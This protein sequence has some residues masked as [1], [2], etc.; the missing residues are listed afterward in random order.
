MPDGGGHT[1]S[2]CI[3]NG[4]NATVV[5]RKLYFSG[6]L[7]IGH[8]A[9][10][11]PV[12]L[13][14]KPVFA[15]YRFQLKYHFNVLLQFC[16][17]VV[18][19][20]KFFL[21]VF[22]AHDGTGCIA[23]HIGQLQVDGSIAF[24]VFELQVTVAGGFTH[25]IH[26]RSLAPGHALKLINIFFFH[27]QAHSF[28]RFVAHNFARRQGGITHRQFVNMDGSASCFHQLREAIEVASGTMV[29]DGNDRVFIMFHH[30]TDGIHGPFLHFGVRTLYGI[31]LNGIGEFTCGNRR[32]RSAT[33]PNTVIVT[34]QHNHFIAGCRCI[35]Q[36]IG[37]FAKTNPSCQHDNF[38]VGKSFLIFGMLEGKQGTTDQGLAE[39][40]AKIAGTIGGLD[41]DLI[42]C[43]VQPGSFGDIFLPQ[44]ITFLAGIG[45][46][47]YCG[48]SQGQRT[49]PPGQA[50]TDLTTGACCSTIKG[51]NSCGKVMGFS[52]Q[53]NYRFDFLFAEKVRFILTQWSKLYSIR[54]GNKGHIVFI[55]RHQIIG[56]FP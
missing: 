28:L 32:N 1:Q 15:G 37:F 53:G 19:G 48:A 4:G 35:F 38:V 31:E 49:F 2:A 8:L 16:R 27:Y 41:Q 23:K 21:T 10:Y 46:H 56:V 50:I 22:I 44:T 29:M 39:F 43:L 45:S 11:R 33:H 42:R 55:G 13:I 14:G 7:L 6:T 25:Y 54:P 51:F 36:A 24:I 20:R 18:Q 17:V 12:N 5:E 52:F 40:I 3:V 26:G 47:V 9:R 30:G 34:S